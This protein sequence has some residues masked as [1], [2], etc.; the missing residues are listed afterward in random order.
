MDGSSAFRNCRWRWRVRETHNHLNRHYFEPS[1]LC[2][3]PDPEVCGPMTESDRQIY[4]QLLEEGSE[5]LAE[6]G[7]WPL[8][9]EALSGRHSV[10]M[11]EMDIMHP[12]EMP[13]AGTWAGSVV[14]GIGPYTLEY[15]DSVKIVIAE[16]FGTISP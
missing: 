14:Y 16:V 1:A 10:R 15:Q 11:E 13:A 3:T 12:Q 7:F 5:E 8:M 9:D 2:V 4:Y 6:T